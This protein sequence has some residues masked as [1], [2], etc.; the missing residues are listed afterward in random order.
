MLIYSEYSIS[1]ISEY[2]YFSTE[3]YFIRI[4]RKYM[5]TTPARYRKY[6]REQERW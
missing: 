4:F 6:Y 1:E 3:S 2:L 5:G